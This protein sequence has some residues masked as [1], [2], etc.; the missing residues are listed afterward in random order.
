MIMVICESDVM[1]VCLYLCHV[2]SPAKSLLLYLIQSPSLSI[3][4]SDFL[5]LLLC[6]TSY[7][8]PCSNVIAQKVK[9]RLFSCPLVYRYY[10]QIVVN[11]KPSPGLLLITTTNQIIMNVRCI[12]MIRSYTR[13]VIS[14]S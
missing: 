6:V 10:I 3:T 12:Y 14:K 1:Y 7:A 4:I 5:K 2:I 8:I 9:S 13:Q 11:F